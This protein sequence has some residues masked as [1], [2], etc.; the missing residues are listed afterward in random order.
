MNYRLLAK[1]LGG[2]LS[3]LALGMIICLL[4]ALLGGESP[5]F[6]R[7]ALY[8]F[9]ISAT[10]TLSVA[11]MLAWL[12]RNSGTHLLRKEAVALVGL[13]WIAA[14]I[15]GALPYIFAANNISPAAAIFESV[16]GFTT[17]GASVIADLDVVPRSVL[18]WRAMTHWLGGLGI[19]VLFVAVLSH[20]GPGSKSLFRHENAGASTGGFDPRAQGTAVLLL[21][22]YVVLTVVCTLGLWFFGM[23]L[24]DAVTHAMATVSTGGFSTRN[25]SIAYY[26]SPAIELWITAFMVLGGISLMLFGWLVRRRFERWKRDEETKMYLVIIFF[27]TAL[28]AAN[29]Y[30]TGESDTWVDGLRAAL[31]QVV[32]I[33]T[34]TGFAT[35]DFAQWPDFSMGVLVVLMFVGGCVGSTAGGIKVARIIICLKLC[36]NGASAF[37]R[38]GLVASLRINGLPLH[39]NVPMQ[40]LLFITVVGFSLVVGILLF[41]LF[42]PGLDLLSVVTGV[43]ACTF[44][45]GPALGQL[46][47]MANFS[48]LSSAS[49]FLL[50]LLML[51]GRLEFFAVL[52]LFSPSLWRRF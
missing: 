32:S 40:V 36:R 35:R 37:F 45:I 2:V 25:T 14:G 46:G 15:F 3:L 22:I 33:M 17:T 41:A 6:K 28:I 12:G 9:G 27:G 51:L 13:S 4:D 31:F 10:I 52:A 7:V 30:F 29:L 1:I 5:G 42:E 21:K 34:T 44:N 43:I 8:D 16:S 47:P 48:E 18:L 26:E 49:Y 23:S 50:S 11:G 19:A 39:Q 24:F 20:F 38:P